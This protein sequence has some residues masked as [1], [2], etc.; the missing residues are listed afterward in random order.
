[1]RQ[2]GGVL[3][4]LCFGAWFVLVTLGALDAL[5]FDGVELF[6]IGNAAVTALAVWFGARIAG[7]YI[8]RK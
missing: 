4:A 3:V 7:W 8:G 2:I 1:M 5:G 6:P